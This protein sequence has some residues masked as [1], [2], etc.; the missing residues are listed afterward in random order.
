MKK[1]SL[2]FLLAI[3]VF[4]ATS[5]SAQEGVLVENTS[6]LKTQDGS[7]PDSFSVV[8]TSSGKLVVKPGQ[9]FTEGNEAPGTVLPSLVSDPKPISYPRWA[10]DQ[11]WQGK[12]VI[13]LEILADGSVG[14]YQVM[15][16]TGYQILDEAATQA[17]QSWKFH[18]AVKKDGQPFRTCI[19]VPITFQLQG[20]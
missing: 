4:S 5:V 14:L 10:I 12:I 2:L 1:I 9:V 15:H 17:V 8:V 3:L 20:E 19:Q 6:L 16:S 11:G 13:A 18:P 7:L